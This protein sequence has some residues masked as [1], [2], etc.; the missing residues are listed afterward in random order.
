MAEQPAPAAP[1]LDD[2][3][4][5]QRLHR[6]EELL[7]QLEQVPGRT[8]DVAREAVETLTEVYG[9][10]LGRAVDAATSGADVREV[11]TG[12]ELLRHLLLLHGLHP[13]PIGMRLERAIADARAQLG[14]SG[15]GVMLV[16]VNGG[17]AE[18]RLSAGGCGSCGTDTAVEDVVRDELLAAAPELAGVAFVAA[19]KQ[20]PLIPLSTVRTRT[21]DPSLLRGAAPPGGRPA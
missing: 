21:A 5:E 8:A 9:E 7:G 17:V 16:G 2:P 15:D 13:D 14:A 3:A 6:L 4:L 18:V 19:E 11:L 10:A 1:G 12:D 20:A